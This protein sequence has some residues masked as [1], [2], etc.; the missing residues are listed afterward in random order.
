MT[1]AS[2][3]AITLLHPRT[4][5]DRLWV[6]NSDAHRQLITRGKPA[7]LLFLF[8]AAAL[9][10]AGLGWFRRS[11]W[12]W[13]LATVIVAVQIVGDFV[14]LLRGDWVR[15]SIGLVIGSALL[16]YML[17]DATRS[18]FRVAAENNP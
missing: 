2:Y 12:G 11:L 9:A 10:A 7:G 8:L 4:A 18:Q 3:A 1:M 5:L 15:G 13:R 16:L 14:N 17:S 6:L